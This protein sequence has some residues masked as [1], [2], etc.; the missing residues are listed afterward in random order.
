[1]RRGDSRSA[2]RWL[3]LLCVVL[4]TH[5]SLYPWRFEWPARPAA[6]WAHMMQQTSWWTGLGDVVGNVVLFVPVGVL[7]LLVLEHAS[8]RPAL[9][10][11]L[12]LCGGVAFAFALQVA[13]IFV[14]ARDAALSDVAWNALGLAS[15][16]LLARVARTVAAR[17]WMHAGSTL[18]LPML[19][20]GLWLALEWWPFVPT[21]DWQHVKD[22]LK[23]LLL[24]PRWNGWRAIEVA[25][26]LLVVAQALRDSAHRAV[27]LAGLVAL[28]ALGKLFISGQS[29]SLSHAVGWVAGLLVAA[30]WWRI[31]ARRAVHL[32]V[33]LALAWFTLDELRPFTPAA[34]S[35]PFHWIPFVVLLEGSLIVNTAA[36]TW[37]L[38]WL[39]AVMVFARQLGA[40]MG[41][42]AIV[43]GLWA[44]LLEG[45]QTWLPGRVADITPALLPAFWWL[46]LRALG[47]AARHR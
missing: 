11:A 1:M 36:L 13:Q 6:A 27:L 30:A 21:I 3:A 38:F 4:V 25:L 28:A 15:G 32:A 7:G 42:L 9:R 20:A 40:R 19:L 45:A 44:L 34:S 39:G 24:A 41:A 16:M 8:L 23:P 46:L 47:P 10:T 17:G 29:L 37:N 26:S 12:V 18:P 33:W 35:S 31:P 5:G 43:L 22:A 2:L 14:P